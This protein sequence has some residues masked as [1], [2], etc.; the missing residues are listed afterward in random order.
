MAACSFCDRDGA[1]AGRLVSGRASV[2]CQSCAEAA[3]KEAK[4][5][6]TARLTVIVLQ[7]NPKGGPP[8][9][10][11]KR[12]G[13]GG[14]KPD[15]GCCGF[16]E[17][18]WR[19]AKVV[20]EGARGKI[21]HD[22]IATVLRV[23]RAP[24]PARAARPAPAPA[25]ARAAVPAPAPA[26]APAAARKPAAPPP[27][28]L[29]PPSGHRGPFT[30]LIRDEGETEARSQ[31]FTGSPLIAG[32]HGAV[33]LTGKSVLPEHVR[34]EERAGA[35]TTVPVDGAVA[36]VNG[37]RLRAPWV[38]D[39]G[40]QIALGEAQLVFY[41]D[42]A[43]SPLGE[44]ANGFSR[45]RHHLAR[46]LA[47]TA[48][49]D[50]KFVEQLADL[51][52]AIENAEKRLV[53]QPA[54]EKMNA[55]NWAGAIAELDTA[56]RVQPTHAGALFHKAYCHAHLGD[57]EAAR[58]AAVGARDH[59]GDDDQTR[60]QAVDLLAQI[61]KIG[62][63]LALQAAIKKMNDDDL[64]AAE[65]LLDKAVLRYPEDGAILYHLAI[66]QAKNEKVET[67]ENTLARAERAT[68]DPELL[69]AIRDMKAQLQGAAAHKAAEGTIDAA[70]EAFKRDDVATARRLFGSLPA[71]VLQVP[72]IKYMWCVA[73]AKVLAASPWA[74]A[75]DTKVRIMADLKDVAKRAQDPDLKRSAQSVMSQLS[76]L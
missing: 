28:A 32:T 68:R 49:D 5:P 48:G 34:F 60:K 4:E 57:F 71:D 46:A 26:P 23:L 8:T 75:G 55:E 61:E 52:E 64:G 12:G 38:L 17:R 24:A 2:I 7:A 63:Q 72:H 69:K 27:D 3:E 10:M 73:R 43:A 53:L 30:L 25:P 50:R 47:L 59:A 74:A 14:G 67:A 6:T 70:M 16:C 45:A 62:P 39:V 33:R 37:V 51:E 21:C 13:I 19:D 11:H 35:W 22:C 40:D 9:A 31:R 15:D 18:T 36:R 1:E 58:K 44:R 66:C 41:P 42:A 20:V 56:L 29:P 65:R 54:I 76:G